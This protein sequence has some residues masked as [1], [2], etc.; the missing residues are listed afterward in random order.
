[1]VCLGEDPV[2]VLLQVGG[3]LVLGVELLGEMFCTAWEEHLEVDQEELLLEDLLAGMLKCP[4][5]LVTPCLEGQADCPEDPPAWRA[6]PGGQLPSLPPWSC[7]PPPSP[8]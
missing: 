6:W 2:V 4:P 1:M 8:S 5:L 7:A 3:H